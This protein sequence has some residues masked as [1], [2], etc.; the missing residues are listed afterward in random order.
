LLI[1]GRNYGT[2]Q[3]R[4]DPY[5]PAERV[6]PIHFNVKYNNSALDNHL[7]AR[8]LEGCRASEIELIWI[9]EARR[10]ATAE[11]IKLLCAGNLERL[12]IARIAQ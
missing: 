3:E 6:R 4:S 1:I 12:R 9:V 11:E 8:D 5:L 10:R 7:L 2:Q